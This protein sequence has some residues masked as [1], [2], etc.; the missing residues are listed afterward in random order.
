MN[1][2][3]G[4]RKK[5]EPFPGIDTKATAQKVALFLEQYPD[6]LAKSKLSS[7]LTGMRLDGMPRGD[8]TVNHVEKHVT[9]RLE[10]EEFIQM[11]NSIVDVIKNVYGEDQAVILRLGFFKI[12]ITDSVIMDQI[13][14]EKS[15]FYYRKRDALCHFALLWPSELGSLVVYE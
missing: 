4:A 5:R 10:A 2:K 8:S 6:Q 12:G 3:K 11:C 1:T 15:Q 7:Q 9:D 13:M 14:L